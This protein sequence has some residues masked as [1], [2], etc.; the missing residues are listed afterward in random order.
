MKIIN[1]IMLLVL[2]TI[3]VQ[4]ANSQTVNVQQVNT[5]YFMDNVPQRNN[6]NPA[7][8]PFS[9][10]YIGLPVVGFTRLS[11]GNS[12]P[13]LTN[14]VLDPAGGTDNFYNSLTDLT[15]LHTNMQLNLLSFGFRSDNSYWNFSLTENINGQMA[16]TK[17]LFKLLLY[18]TPDV[19]SF[20]MK[21]MS[22]NM[23]AYTEVAVGYSNQLSD[24]WSIGGKLKFLYGNNDISFNTSGLTLNALSNSLTLTGTG[25]L[26]NNGPLSIKPAGL[27]G[28]VDVGFTY[29]PDKIITFSG[30]VTDLGM[31]HWNQKVYNKANFSYT[32]ITPGIDTN[33]DSVRN[34]IFTGL[35]NSTPDSV[36]SAY[37][38][39]TTPKLNI[40]AEFSLLDNKLSLGILSR[41]LW[42]NS[43]FNEE[44]TASINGRPVDWMNLSLSYSVF[45]GKS[46]NIGLGMGLRTGPLHWFL[47]A[48]YIPFD[49]NSIHS[50]N[51]PIPYNTHGVN[52]GLGLTIVLGNRKDADRD[53]VTDKKDLCPKTPKGVKV[54]VNGCPI[55][56]DGDGIPDYLDK[57]PNTPPEAKNF[58][59]KDGCP[60]DADGDGVPDYMDE[61]PDTPKDAIGFVDKKG[62]TLDSDGDGIPDNLDKCPNT[63]AEAKDLVDKTGCLVDTDGDGV[64]DFLDLC[65]NSPSIAKGFVDK[66]GCTLDSDGDGIPDYLDK[67]PE[68]PL[69]AHGM[70]DASGC[71]RDTDGDGVPDYLDKCPTI[72]GTVRNNGCPEAKIE[73]KPEVIPEIKPEVIPLPKVEINKNLKVLFEKALQGI[74]FDAARYSIKPESYIILD[75]IAEALIDNQGY[76]IEI[77]GHTNSIGSH[78]SNML[79]SQKRAQAVLTYL[80]SKG[81]DAKRMNSVGFGDTLPV[82]SNKTPEGRALNRRVEFSVTAIK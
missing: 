66:N 57:C 26:N 25:L 53:G 75:Q 43:E 1:K 46:S 45:N 23:T 77:Q 60:L 59:D 76:N 27:G 11:V 73:V 42:M 9:D 71:P 52:L 70:V 34:C 82:A 54:D 2:A 3:V 18:G 10:F 47:S 37:N 63:P 22:M 14:F 36:G 39:F 55:D 72:Q 40:G 30:A 21:N 13:I 12:S 61:C 16:I 68:T 19:N 6:L 29:K 32:G 8:Q 51:L 33:L 58:I 64:P 7:F 28:A 65:P 15:T 78:E 50:F 24:K 80:V 17:D 44:V 41:S 35:N 48:D 69:E 74:Q 81:V 62:C 67:C 56:S 5:M 79:L 38:T 31:I 49:K 20:S 4:Q